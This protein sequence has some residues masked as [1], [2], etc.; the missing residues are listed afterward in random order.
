MNP[1]ES[2]RVAMRNAGLDY[3][4]PIVSDGRLHRFKAAGDHARNSWYV[5]HDGTPA[6][7]MFG[8]WK[9]NFS[10]KWHDHD[11][12]KLTASERD[13][14]RRRIA[15]AEAERKRIEELRQRKARKIAE[16]IFSRSTPAEATYA[17]LV[18]KGVQPHGELRQWRGKLIIPLRDEG[19]ELHSLQFIVPDGSK[20]FLAGGRVAGCFFALPDNGATALVICEGF[21][22]A[23]S[24]TE[25]T[26]VP[27]VAAM[28]CG[29]LLAVAKTLRGKWPR[30]D[31][32]IAADN[33][34]WTDGNPGVTKAAQAAKASHARLIVPQF[35]DK[36]TK[37]TDFNDLARLEGS[38]AVKDQIQ[39]AMPPQET[40]EEA[41]ER[42]AKLPPSD[43]D[44]VR[45][46]EAK[47]LGI[48]TVT[49]DDEVARR[50]EGYADGSDLQGQA[51]ELANVELWAESVSGAEAL[52]GVV[53]ILA[54][55]VVLPASAADAIALW[56]AH[57]HVFRVFMH[58]PRL[59]I[60]SPEKRCG[61]TTLRDVLA[62][63][64][65]RPLATENLSV[66]VLFR[67]ID[68][69]QPTVLADEY[70]AWIH[71]NEELRGL[72]NAGHKRGAKA[73]RCEGD[74]HEVR[75]F[76]VFAPVVL[77]GIGNL[78]GTLHDRSL[79]IKLVRAKPGE[80]KAGFD[81][82]RIQAE[83]ELCRKLARWC[84]DHAKQIEDCDPPMPAGAF[85]RLA[86][87]WRPLF[88]V[89]E[90]AGGNWPQRAARSF[91]LLTSQ[92]D[93]DADGIGTM[94]LTD[95]RSAFSQ[96]AGDRMFS[97]NLL[98]SLRAMPE[99]PW[100][101]IRKGKEITGAWLARHLRG[102]AITSRKIRIGDEVKQGYLRD[103]FAEA[104]ERYLPPEVETT[105]NGGTTLEN[106][107]IRG[108]G[109]MEHSEPVFLFENPRKSN[110][111]AGCTTVPLPNPT[112][113]AIVD[114][115]ATI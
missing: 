23:A 94:L 96:T 103:D 91:A 66:A 82:R 27:V 2:F 31:F 9:R 29:N 8:C 32:I 71:E 81:S 50:R 16:W 35:K 84:A 5:L 95:I 33:D 80:V 41:Y 24:I 55:Y 40:D 98:E 72:L 60:Q 76:N 15:E 18:A 17:Y 36:T 92:E 13:A 14:I 109:E 65:P 3:A 93:A 6:A 106:T 10:Q 49:L 42:L 19:G 44:R 22:T 77:A 114:E 78:P 69:Y 52:D 85:N 108:S 30:R 74:N 11:A 112:E 107:G 20:L 54:K 67:L 86:D 56:V 97:E 4:G 34:Q 59:N 47:R 37:P 115:F 1:T 83:A 64:V 68:K 104:W 38:N 7:G 99:R 28:N 70:D 57:A 73:Y 61:K 62:T 111:G 53:E 45:A 90:V 89:A 58:T 43:Y 113:E 110:T 39:R 79:V 51:V 75:G 102:F 63:L 100:R 21:A 26:G 25:A 46:S 87:N 12:K 88:A 105:R 48:R 101:E